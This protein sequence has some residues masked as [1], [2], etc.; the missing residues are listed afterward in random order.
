MYI[1][2][3]QFIKGAVAFAAGILGAGLIGK[4]SPVGKSFA[5]GIGYH[6]EALYYNKIDK[7]TVEC[8]LCPRG[9]V[10]KNGQRS[11]CRVREPKDGK[12]YTLVYE[13]ACS[14]YVD[15]IEKKPI[16]HML[17]GSQSF[18]IATAGCNLRCKFCQN[19]Q[20]SQEGP[21]GTRNVYLP[22]AEIVKQARK[23][24]CRSIAYT[25]S[26]PT[27]FYE[28]MMD[29]AKIAKAHGLKNIY[30]T[31]GFI[32]R[33]PLEKLCGVIDAANIDLKGFSDKYLKET[34][35]E[36]LEPLL[37]AIKITKKNGVWVELTNLIIPTLN[38]D[39]Q[40]IKNMCRW[41]K[42]N[43]GSDT[44]LHFSRFWP[45]YKF[46]N[47]PPTPLSTLKRAESIAKGEGLNFVYIGNVPEEPASD[48]RCPRCKK[49]VIRR[50]GFTVLKNYIVDSKCKF[51]GA[52]IAGIW[53]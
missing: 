52:E 44:P 35:A 29:T 50:L 31:G 26:E 1:T 37:E 2:R 22:C 28:Y 30:V 7:D 36:S 4:K 25:Y 21:E 39:P 42:E 34:C 27:V 17:P 23:N 41:I 38:D 48:T 12:L 24:N 3:R 5:S 15:P 10:L 53:K 51:C 13:L 20:I 49:V 16:Y 6:K 14:A 43:V 9:C 8:L 46:K 45:V 47:L 40:M 32:S 19:W 33:Q 11:F 18:S